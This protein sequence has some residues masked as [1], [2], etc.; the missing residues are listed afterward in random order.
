M[1]FLFQET[2]NRGQ[3][4][5]ELPAASPPEKINKK[6]IGFLLSTVS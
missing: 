1:A 4:T 3:E 6:P 5:D 2:G